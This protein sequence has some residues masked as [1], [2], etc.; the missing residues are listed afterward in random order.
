MPGFQDISTAAIFRFD[1]S[2]ELAFASDLEVISIQ[3]HDRTF[4]QSISLA[5]GDLQS[6]S[7]GHT[8]LWRR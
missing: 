3:H 1:D 5:I 4:P 6:T 2:F 8:G 7:A